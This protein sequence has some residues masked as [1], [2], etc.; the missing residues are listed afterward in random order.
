MTYRLKSFPIHIINY[1]SRQ[2]KK[3]NFYNARMIMKTPLNV[4]HNHLW[5]FFFSRKSNVFENNKNK[6]EWVRER[7]KGNLS[8]MFLS[9]FV[10]KANNK[11][12][13]FMHIELIYEYHFLN[14]SSSLGSIYEAHLLY[15]D[16]KK[17]WYRSYYTLI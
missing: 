12:C 6:R 10:S 9:L 5:I 11:V 17:H 14:S 2:K 13:S 4:N 1:I 3:K 15:L 16:S 7:E 8:A